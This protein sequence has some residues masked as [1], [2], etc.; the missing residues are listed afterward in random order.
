MTPTQEA[1]RE[2]DVL[3]RVE[4]VAPVI[5]ICFMRVCVE[6]DVGDAEVLSVVN[7]ENPSGTSNGWSIV[8]RDGTKE[9]G[10]P[11]ACADNAE[12]LHLMVEC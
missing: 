9:Q 1:E 7:R 2:R 4:I 10:G 3:K 5:G 11:V 12:R 6:K 8:H